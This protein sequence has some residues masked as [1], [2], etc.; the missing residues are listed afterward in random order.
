MKTNF[1]CSIKLNTSGE[2][3]IFS[4]LLHVDRYIFIYIYIKFI[5]FFYTLR[6]GGRGFFLIVKLSKD[7]W[8]CE[9]VHSELEPILLIKYFFKAYTFLTS[10][11]IPHL[12]GGF[13]PYK[14]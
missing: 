7:I 11:F 13:V 14:I 5:I 1:G 2:E 4:S 6:V 10:I 3:F 8:G 12:G 9:A